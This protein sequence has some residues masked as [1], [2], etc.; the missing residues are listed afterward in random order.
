MDIGL[1]GDKIILLNRFLMK[2]KG[3]GG[4]GNQ[5]STTIRCTKMQGVLEVEAY[6]KAN[7]TRK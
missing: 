1:A 3:K 7:C 2:D 5:K 6:Q 4:R